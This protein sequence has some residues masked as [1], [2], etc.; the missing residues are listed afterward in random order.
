M[1]NEL[2]HSPIAHQSFR[3]LVSRGF[4]LIELMVA[5]LIGLLVV[6]GATSIFLTVMQTSRQAEQVARLHESI[7]FATDILIRDIRGQAAEGVVT[8]VEHG[9][10]LELKDKGFSSCQVYSLSAND[11][12]E[13]DGKVLVGGISDFKVERILTGTTEWIG[14]EITVDFIGVDGTVIPVKFRA[15]ARNAILNLL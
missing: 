10:K 9:D 11:E 8:S 6:G 1:I 14:Y 13:C 5:M 15:A 7:R 3:P 4:T 12:L 2:L